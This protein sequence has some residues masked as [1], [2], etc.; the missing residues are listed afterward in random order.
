M[1]AQGETREGVRVEVVQALRDGGLSFNDHH[2]FIFDQLIEDWRMRFKPG[3]LRRPPGLLLWFAQEHERAGLC[4]AFAAA[5]A[6]E[7]RAVLRL[8]PQRAP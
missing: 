1:T 8:A 6:D 2:Y 4:P 5:V 3:G 7:V